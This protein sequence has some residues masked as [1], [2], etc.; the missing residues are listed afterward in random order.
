MAR[1]ESSA[2]SPAWVARTELLLELVRLDT[3][4]ADL[5]RQRARETAASEFSELDFKALKNAEQAVQE[6]PADIRRAMDDG[7]WE[8]VKGLTDELGAKQRF[9][10]ERGSLHKIGEWELAAILAVIATVMPEDSGESASSR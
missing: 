7:K 3:A 2:S 4:Y 8:Q 1:K 5:Y 6:L 10:Q 9:L